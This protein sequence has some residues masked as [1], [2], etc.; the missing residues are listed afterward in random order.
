MSELIQFIFSLKDET[1]KNIVR[2]ILFFFGIGVINYS[3]HILWIS[4]W[5]R[6]NLH[7]TRTYFKKNQVPTE[8]SDLPR[9][10]REAKVFRW[11]I[12]Y[13]RISDLVRIKQNGGE[14]DNDALADILAGEAS[15][16][17][18]FSN[19]I[20]GILIILGLIGT[21]RGLIT[22]IIEVQPLFQDIEDL[23]QLPIISKALRETLAGM[24]TAFVTTLAGLLTSLALGLFG[25]FFSR[26]QSAFL[27]GFERFISTDIIPHFTQAPESSIEAAVGQLAECTDTLKFAT[28][29]NVS[30]IEQVIQQLTDTSWSG[31]L[32]QQYILADNF[33]ETAVRLL[34]SLERINIHQM[35]IESTTKSFEDLTK[36]S[37][38]KIEGYQETLRQGLESSASKIKDQ[39]VENQ[40]EMTATLTQLTENSQKHLGSVVNEQNGILT[41]IKT[42]LSKNQQETMNTL[43]Q[44]ANDIQEQDQATTEKQNGILTSI[45][46]QLSKNQQEMINTL[47]Q[48]VDKYQERSQ[49]LTNKQ[50]GI[51]ASIETQLSK[52]QQETM[53]TLTQLAN[54]IQG[55]DQVA[56]EK[57]N[58]ILT[59]I[60]TQLSKNQQETMNTFMQ[61]A[62][63][64]QE[65]ASASA[66]EQNE[67]LKGIEIQS[68]KM[69]ERQ[70]K[71]IDA[72]V[73]LT[74]GLQIDSALEDQNHIFGRIEGHLI[75]SQKQIFNILTR[76][77]DKLQLNSELETQKQILERIEKHLIG[78]EDLDVQR[79]RLIQTLNARVQQLSKV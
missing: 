55:R 71:T 12:I 49:A 18:S 59:S 24:N 45:E 53:N 10:L 35:I 19:Y 28:E 75:D 67:V 58:G 31:R 15:R 40:K 17:A 41:S 2:L 43:T 20:L 6:V 51:L 4:I 62:D 46:I 66:T 30:A 79:S 7:R 77:E 57:Q 47:T 73:E 13:R 25:W 27:T 52:N 50:N 39:L 38:S 11:S 34:E 21:L 56:M 36:I 29:K 63:Q 1:G 44:L 68:S 70:Q 64:S 72:L 9:K 33:G 61:V 54:D 42:Q 74:N 23:D 65:R 69:T 60:E 5:E 14:I 48:A 37:M 32:E 76:L 22:A 26:Q 3:L 78:H 8:V 16:K